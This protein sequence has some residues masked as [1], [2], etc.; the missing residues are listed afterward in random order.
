MSRRLRSDP[1]RRLPLSQ[2]WRRLVQAAR[3][4]VGI[5]DY[6]AYLEH[7]RRA[8]PGTAPMDEAAF[9]RERLQA[10]YGRGRSR[11]C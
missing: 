5:P 6:G 9:F 4:A 7:M 11:C 2:A 3:L 8:H 10:R 1:S